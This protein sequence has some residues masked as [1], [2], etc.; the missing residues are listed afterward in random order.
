MQPTDEDPTGPSEFDKASAVALLTL[1]RFQ[2]DGATEK[3]KMGERVVGE[4][5]D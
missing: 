3:M 5:E 2:Q 4:G 1:E